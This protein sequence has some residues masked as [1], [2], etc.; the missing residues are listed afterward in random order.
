LIAEWLATEIRRELGKQGFP[1][2]VQIRFLP[3]QP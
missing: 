2:P 1:Q 3:K